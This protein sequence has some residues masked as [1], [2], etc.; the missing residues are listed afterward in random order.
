MGGLRRARLRHVRGTDVR[1]LSYPF[2]VE[3]RIHGR[4]GR[5][6]GESF[7][8]RASVRTLRRNF[9]FLE[10]PEEAAS[11]AN[12]LIEA[13]RAVTESLP[14]ERALQEIC[15]VLCAKRAMYGGRV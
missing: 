2:A 13:K 9:F 3:R 4:R 12:R 8:P 11:I 14:P 5:H 6:G 1:V 7:G 10:A 15:A